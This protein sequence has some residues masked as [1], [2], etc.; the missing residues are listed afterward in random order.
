[1]DKAESLYEAKYLRLTE[2]RRKLGIS[3][4]RRKKLEKE[5]NCA[6]AQELL[7]L[8]EQIEKVKSEEKFLRNR[9]IE[10]TLEADD[11][12]IEWQIAGWHFNG[13]KIKMLLKF[14]GDSET[15]LREY[16]AKSIEEDQD[17]F[18]KFYSARAEN[19]RNLISKLRS[20]IKSTDDEA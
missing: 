9:V 10:E 18:P 17:V 12:F 4:S 8:E 16:E 13:D 7:I 2:T 5:A 1:M 15:R 6:S 3:I 14:I 20:L 11:H 19:E